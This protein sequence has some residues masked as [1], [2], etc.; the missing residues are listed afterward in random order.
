MIAV[1]APMAGMIS[2]KTRPWVPERDR[3]EDQRGDQGDCIRL[4]QVGGHAGA[5]ADVVTHV[6]GDG[7]RVA[8]VVLRDARL[9]LADEVGADVGGLGEDAAADAHEHREQRGAEAEALE[10]LRGVTLVD[11]HDDRGTEQTEAHRGHADGATGAERDPHTEVA[12]AVARGR[13]DA[14]VGLDGERHAE[15][16][17]ERREQR[18][19]DEEQRPAQLD[20][21]RVGREQEQQPEDEDDEDA[22]GAELAVEVRLGAFLHRSADG[23]HVLGAGVGGEHLTTEEQAE[24]QG[25]D[26]DGE[27]RVD[28]DQVA[29]CQLQRGGRCRGKVGHNCTSSLRTLTH[30]RVDEPVFGPQK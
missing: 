24:H 15:V 20:P 12:V 13:G 29:A 5:V 21:E 27:H 17:D 30:P 26:C 19:D 9:D 4:E 25:D 3:A 14:D 1:T 18:A 11:E 28:K 22:E 10:D 6:V 23:L 2:G 16:A 7:G 8:R